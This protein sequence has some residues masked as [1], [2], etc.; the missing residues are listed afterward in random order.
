M[1]IVKVVITTKNIVNKKLA[2]V[3]LLRVVITP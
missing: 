3:F 2:K 1:T